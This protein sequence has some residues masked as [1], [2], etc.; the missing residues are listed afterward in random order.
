MPGARAVA[1]HLVAGDA[2]T[3]DHALAAV[4]SAGNDALARGAWDEAARYFEAA[5]T[6]PQAPGEQAELHRRAGLS[7]RGNLQLAPAVVHF[8]QALHLLGPDADAAARAELH[9]WR[10]RCGIG[11]R[12]MLAVVADRGPLEALVDEIEADDPELAAEA[13]VELSQSYWVEWRMKEATQCAHRAMAIAREHDDH[14]AY[15]RATTVLSVPQWARYDLRGSLASLEDGVAHARAAADESLLAGGP[16]FRVPLVLTWLGEFDDAETRALECCD[17][18]DRVQYPLEL[19]LPLAALTQLAVARGEFD[20]AEQYAHRAL[21]LQRLSGYHWA[22][23]LFLP[24][25]A[26]AHVARGQYE[27]ARDA[28]ATWSSTADDLEQASIDLFT[29]WVDAC[30][31]RLVVQGAP[32]PA[33]P[34]DPLVGADAWAALAVELAQREGARG[35]LRAAR[36]LLLAIEERGGV[37]ISGTATLVA[38]HLGV[39]QDLLGDDDAAVDTLRRAIVIARG[40]RA[41]PEVARAQ[42]DLAVIQLR[43]GDRRA[44]VRAARPGGGGVPRAG[45]GA[46]RG[47]RRS[48]SAAPTPAGARGRTDRGDVGVD[49]PLHR[50]RRLDPA[51]RG[52]RR[53]ATTAPGP[54]WPSA[55][56]PAPSSPTGAPSSPASAW[57]TASSVSS[58]PWR[59]PSTPPAAAPTT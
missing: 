31:R 45:H 14:S 21:L 29:R 17:I 25:L 2:V 57:A 51:H 7:R 16:L 10:I 20:R 40:L 19:G 3:D 38:R 37:L 49:H 50:H 15:A 33:L 1:H 24:V 26:W 28:L 34:R 47:P 42:A 27:Q 5:L 18:A 43:R 11:T 53:R 55:P 39:A 9:V 22:A 44:R 54:G 12:E 36:D 58:P 30:E 56:S 46:R 8:E 23:G 6:R 4:R 59:R 32:L 52:A 48:S 35:D 13:L 41:T